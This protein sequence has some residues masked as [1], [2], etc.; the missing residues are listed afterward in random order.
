MPVEQSFF[1]GHLNSCFIWPVSLSSDLAIAAK[2]GTSPTSSAYQVWLQLQNYLLC[3]FTDK[4]LLLFFFF[5]LVPSITFIWKCKMSS[6]Y[7]QNPAAFSRTCCTCLYS[8]LDLDMAFP[9]TGGGGEASAHMGQAG[10]EPWPGLSGGKLL[11]PSQS[12]S[13]GSATARCEQSRWLPNP[14]TWQTPWNC[15][16]KPRIFGQWRCSGSKLLLC[17]FCKALPGAWLILAQSFLRGRFGLT[18]SWD[19]E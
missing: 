1:S 13:F 9:C 18:F 4:L 6:W 11:F 19:L 5:F 3:M 2:P 15:T 7:D 10:D 16:S 14:D 12:S 17:K 8:G